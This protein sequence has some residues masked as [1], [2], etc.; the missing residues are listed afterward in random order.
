M[1]LGQFRN[2]TKQAWVEK[3]A[4]VQL[5]LYIMNTGNEQDFTKFWRV[6]RKKAVKTN[7][8]ESVAL[9]VNHNIMKTIKELHSD[10]NAYLFWICVLVSIDQNISKSLET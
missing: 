10:Q 9:S 2:L 6:L 7:I 3:T 8:N 1:R 5:P 4:D